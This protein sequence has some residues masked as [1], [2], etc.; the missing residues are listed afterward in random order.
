MDPP[1]VQN[2][3]QQ[4]I[5][6][7]SQLRLAALCGV[8]AWRLETRPAGRIVIEVYFL[9]LWMK[10]TRLKVRQMFGQP[11]EKKLYKT[12]PLALFRPSIDPQ[13]AANT[14]R[15]N[16]RAHHQTWVIVMPERRANKIPLE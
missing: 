11:V 13:S 3:W 2:L 8:T 16:V 14:D 15:L 7:G 10:G 12:V 9:P 5:T 1:L 4:S 6:R